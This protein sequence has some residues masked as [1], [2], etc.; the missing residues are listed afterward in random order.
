M[1]KDPFSRPTLRSG[2]FYREPI[3]AIAWLEQAFGFRQSMMVQDTEGAL[4]HAEMVYK[5]ACIVIDSQWAEFVSSP[6][7]LQGRNSQLVYIQLDNNI[8]SHF[9]TAKA[10][11]ATIIQ[12]LEDQYYGDSV[13]RAADLE[14][15]IWTFSQAITTVSREEAERLGNVTIDGWHG[16]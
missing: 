15:H 3:K 1:T 12:Q 14:G 7:A 10:A 13:Y 4:I 8:E 6:L 11:G 2:L 9:F 5:D 16:E